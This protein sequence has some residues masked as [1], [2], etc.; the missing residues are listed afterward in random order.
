MVMGSSVTAVGGCSRLIKRA[1]GQNETNIS[2]CT[3]PTVASRTTG[4]MLLLAGVYSCQK[5]ARRISR[6][7]IQE[8]AKSHGKLHNKEF[9]N[10]FVAV[11]DYQGLFYLKSKRLIY[12]EL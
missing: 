1:S 10:Y 5:P 4:I 11:T 9:C 3:A 2:H 6:F 12:V 7:K 8:T